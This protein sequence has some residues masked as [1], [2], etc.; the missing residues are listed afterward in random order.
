MSALA[1]EFVQ[2]L[3]IEERLLDAL[4]TQGPQ[5]LEEI[6]HF[7]TD[8]SWVQVFLAVDRL[9]RAEAIS[10]QPVRRCEY[11]VALIRPTA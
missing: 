11:R 9:S 5:M 8:A 4:R 2:A 10:L 6:V 7:L 1:Y 3:S